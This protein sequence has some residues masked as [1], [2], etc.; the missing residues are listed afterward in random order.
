MTKT[1]Y[2][3]RSPLNSNFWKLT[4]FFLFIRGSKYESA[5][6]I[7]RKYNRLSKE[8]HHQSE[9]TEPELCGLYCN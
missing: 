4:K 2:V 1:M 7:K 8:H 5:L 6:N 3:Q 9:L